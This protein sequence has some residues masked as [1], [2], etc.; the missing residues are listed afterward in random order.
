MGRENQNI[1]LVI[2]SHCIGYIA[3]YST[4]ALSYDDIDTGV[5]FGFLQQIYKFAKLFST[6]DFVFCWDSKVSKRRGIFSEYQVK[7]KTAKLTQEELEFNISFYNQ[8]KELRTE[9][10]PSLG[11]TNIYQKPGY[12]SDDLIARVVMDNVGDFVI[13]SN[14]KD[15]YQLLSYARIYDP[16]TKKTINQKTL[17]N[18]YLGVTPEEWVKVKAIAGCDSDEV[19]GIFG[20]GEKTAI[21]YIKGQI[22]KGIIYDRIKSG[23][24]IINRNLSLV[25][26]PID[27]I[28]PILLNEPRQ[29]L[30]YD[31]FYDLC[32]RLSF[33]SFLRELDSWKEVLI[34][35]RREQFINEGGSS[36]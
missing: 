8:L 30:N 2:D 22:K 19:P 31:Y 27:G 7:R 9:I 13:I 1:T 3:K 33:I 17:A 12:E 5:I 4:G 32:D 36:L 34:L 11:F 24:D 25:K 16:R 15:L 6:I 26:L 10:L 14:D 29:Y 20:V 23:D 21:K 18:E 35:E 28:E